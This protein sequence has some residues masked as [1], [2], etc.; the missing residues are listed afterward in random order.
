MDER[1]PGVSGD[2]GTDRGTI[3]GGLRKPPVLSRA[4]VRAVCGVCLFGIVYG[5]L[6]PLASGGRPWVA[7]VER[8]R[9]IPARHSTDLDDVLTNFLVY[10]P[11]GVALRLLVRRRGQRGKA[12]LHVALVLSALLSYGTELVQQTMPARCAS[13]T[14]VLVN[15]IGAGCGAL[16]AVR[17]QWL[18]RRTHAALFERLRDPQRRWGVVA[19]AG[20]AATV[21]LMTMPWKLRHPTAEWGRV[22]VE[23]ADLGRFGLFCLLGFAFVRVRRACGETDRRAAVRAFVPVAALALLIEVVQSVL[24]GHVCSATHAAMAIL[25]GAVGGAAATRPLRGRT[26]AVGVLAGALV[27]TWAGTF[28]DGPPMHAWRAA[29]VVQWVPFQ[30]QFNARLVVSLSDCAAELATFSALTAACIVLRGRIG[31]ALAALLLTSLVGTCELYRAFVVGRCADTTTPILALAAW[32]LTVRVW[33]AV[34]P[35]DMREPCAPVESVLP[36]ARRV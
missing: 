20:A 10:L 13:L 14:D 7:P 12:D 25:G 32:W 36:S 17:V 21:V 35:D 3:V 4:T 2:R 5:T 22:A 28:P 27:Y 9:W 16:V 19:R 23:L 30:T 11:A 24:S 18:A 8:W 26:L 29:P 33:R 15:S 34:C 6:G 1:L 31:A